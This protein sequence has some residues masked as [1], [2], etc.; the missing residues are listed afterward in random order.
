MRTLKVINTEKHSGTD[1]VFKPGISSVEDCASVAS[2]ISDA[3]S[4]ESDVNLESAFDNGHSENVEKDIEVK[5]ASVL[6]KLEHIF[7]V[8]NAALDELLQELNS[9]IGSLSLPI[10]KK[11]ISQVLQDHGC[12]L[13]PSVVEKL[14]T[15]LCETNPVKKVI[16]DKGPLSSSWRRKFYYKKHFNVV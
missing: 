16:G 13:D 2:G 15:A 5:L 6:L 14:A 12:Q 8:S 3:E 9:L 11:T 10:T 7:L 4:L 1:R